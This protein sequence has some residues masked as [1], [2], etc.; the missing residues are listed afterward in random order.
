[1][2]I[3]VER[4]CLGANAH[5]EKPAI[6]QNVVSF[7]ER[8]TLRFPHIRLVLHKIARN[9]CNMHFPPFEIHPI[10]EGGRLKCP[11]LSI[12]NP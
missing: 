1:M 4:K 2:M 3:S 9:P 6:S 10:Q 12:F 5:E 7:F 8:I 11:L